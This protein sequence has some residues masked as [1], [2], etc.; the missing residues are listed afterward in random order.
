MIE[1]DISKCFDSIDHSKLMKIIE[2][3]I[4]D[5]RFTKLIWKALKA[6]YFEFKE[7]HSNIV[8]TPQ[9]SIISPILANIF[10]SQ[11]DEKIDELKKN[12]DKGTQPRRPKAYHTNHS[13][14][15][16]AKKRGDMKLV[17]EL[18]KKYRQTPS[19]DLEDPNYRRLS[20]VRYADD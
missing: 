8:G 13:R 10:M 7:Y 14:L 19:G 17:R 16:R 11:L 2:E 18:A 1:G 20:Y 3:R 5:R 4:C 12:F 9:G 15:S 6:G